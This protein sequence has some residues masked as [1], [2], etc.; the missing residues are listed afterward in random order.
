MGVGCIAIRF[1]TTETRKSKER[2]SIHY[3][4]EQDFRPKMVGKH[5][6]HDHG[7]DGPP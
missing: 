3:P 4:C 7:T 5:E 2:L 6:R 1:V